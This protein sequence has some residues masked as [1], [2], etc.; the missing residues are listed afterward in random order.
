M[1]QGRPV[2][3]VFAGFIVLMTGCTSY[4]RIEVEQV[5][6][7]DRVRVTTTDLDRKQ[8]IEPSLKVD[9]LRGYLSDEDRTVGREWATPIDLVSEVE[10]KQANTVGTVS[11]VAL[12]V[13]LAAAI[14]SVVDWD[15]SDTF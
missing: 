3:F 14:I 12:G 10:A 8:L 9:S 11:L 2:S 15:D 13:G 7:F 6:N 1:L 5:P 4:Q